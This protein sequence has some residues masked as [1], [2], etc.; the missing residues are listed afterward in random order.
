MI[1]CLHVP[2]SLCFAPFQ[3]EITRSN[4]MSRGPI[5]NTLAQTVYA[6]RTSIARVAACARKKHCPV[7][8][9]RSSCLL[10]NVAVRPVHSL[11]KMSTPCTFCATCS[12]TSFS[13]W[14]A[15]FERKRPFLHL[16]PCQR[17]HQRQRLQL[18]LPLQHQQQQRVQEA[19]TRTSAPSRRISS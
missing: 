12:T 16:H 19:R 14:V 17:P 13:S 1:V 7:K 9:S 10:I 18:P 2:C 15:R 8:K 5:T 11:L 3:R 6:S 4:N